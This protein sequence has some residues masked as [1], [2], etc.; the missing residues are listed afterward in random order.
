MLS[1]RSHLSCSHEGQCD[2]RGESEAGRAW[3]LT[4]AQVAAHPVPPYPHSDEDPEAAVLPKDKLVSLCKCDPV[5]KWMRSCDHILYQALVEILIPDVLR[6]VPSKQPPHRL[7]SSLSLCPRPPRQV[8]GRCGAPRI[9]GEQWL[10]RPGRCS[11]LPACFPC[12]WPRE[13][14]REGPIGG[15][16][17]DCPASGHCLPQPPNSGPGGAQGFKLLPSAVRFQVTSRL[18]RAQRRF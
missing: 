16:S 8:Q 11:P 4:P 10:R 17:E 14:R 2:P 9:Q 6:P 5:L 12:H 3:A 7:L 18:R 1:Q 15:S 13:R